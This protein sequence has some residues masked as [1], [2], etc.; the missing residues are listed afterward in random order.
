LA[1]L[2]GAAVAP[3]LAALAQGKP[4]SP[5]IGVLSMGPGM[6]V[7]E[8]AFKQ[9]LQDFGY[10]AGQ[11]VFLEYRF[12]A[13]SHD[14]LNEHTAELVAAKVDVLLTQGSEATSAA[15]RLTTS[16]PIVMTSTNPVG[17]GF[18]ASLARPGGNITGVS[19]L[20][21]EVAAKRVELL[22]ELLPDIH[23]VAVFW[24]PNDPGARFSLAETQA[25][26]K[27]LKVELL[28][29]E[30]REVADFASAFH[31]AA[32]ESAA[33]VILLPAPL[34]TRENR[35]VIDLALQNRLPTLF[36]SN[37]SVKIGALI[38]YGPSIVTA[39]RRAAYFVDRILKGAS[40]ADLPIEQPTK[41]EL[42]INLKTAKALG[43]NVPATLL[44]RADDVIE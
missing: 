28:V 29:R 34:M 36:Y 22:R 30:T 40:P 26:A 14:R 5:R 13:G 16:I 42:A 44:A 17:L 37:E 41:L 39:Y 25:A 23:K 12:A 6:S 38:A 4:P 1:A 3:P 18:V 32:A 21:P 7:F 31:A 15:R 24:N 11:N 43:L 35:R 2:G 8:E 27:A 9:G 20:G 33:A 10:T 19:L